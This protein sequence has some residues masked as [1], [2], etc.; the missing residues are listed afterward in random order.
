M[1][2]LFP[3][4]TFAQGLINPRTAPGT[5]KIPPAGFRTPIKLARF[6]NAQLTTDFP[7]ADWVH[8]IAWSDSVNQ[9]C[10][11]NGTNWLN[12]ITAAIIV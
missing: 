5:A 11:S 8:N 4:Q 10:Y 1:P 9:P 3:G 6:T 12:L 2:T 7:A